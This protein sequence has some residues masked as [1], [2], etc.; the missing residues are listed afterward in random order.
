MLEN[1]INVILT[2]LLSASKRKTSPRIHEL[3]PIRGN[4]LSGNVYVRYQSKTGIETDDG[5]KFVFDVNKHTLYLIGKSE[6][7]DVALKA[8]TKWLNPET[9]LIEPIR[10]TNRNIVDDIF[11]ILQKSDGSNHIKLLRAVFG[12]TGYTY[13]EVNQLYEIQYKFTGNVCASKHTE[14]TN[15]VDNSTL[16]KVHFGIYDLGAIHQSGAPTSFRVD[17]EFGCQVWFDLDVDSWVEI[18]DIVS[19]FNY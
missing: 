15:F 2:A 3:T 9:E 16:I 5:C 19:D 12:P 13:V 10:L 1:D 18:L 6:T 4:R 14:Y 8:L 7:R 17:H 11:T